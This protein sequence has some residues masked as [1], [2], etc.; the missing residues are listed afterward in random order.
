MKNDRFTRAY[1]LRLRLHTWLKENGPCRMEKIFEAHQDVP[2][3]TVRKCIYAMRVNENVVMHGK[4]GKPGIFSVCSDTIKTE[5]EM[6]EVMRECGMT[7]RDSLIKRNK[8]KGGTGATF[9]K[10]QIERQ[11]I[12]DILN[13]QGPLR[14]MEISTIMGI[15]SDAALRTIYRMEEEGEVVRN[16]KGKKQTWTAI[17]LTTVSADEMRKRIEL[18]KRET[19]E[20]TNRNRQRVAK[21]KE[22]AGYYRHRDHRNIDVEPPLKNQGGQG[23]LRNKVSVDCSQVW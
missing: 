17:V 23:A 15:N 2:H 13:K 7:S 4:L 16:G 5:E 21:V 3:E 10:C 1:E 12:L 14:S 11:S 9:E 19:T 22:I 20:Q 8:E 18:R 6:R